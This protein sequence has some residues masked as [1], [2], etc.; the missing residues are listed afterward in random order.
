MLS[1]KAQ[2]LVSRYS[3]EL[4]LSDSGADSIVYRRLWPD[5]P[6]VDAK[7]VLVG[8]VAAANRCRAVLSRGVG[9]CTVV[10]TA[11]RPRRGR[12]ARHLAARPGAAGHARPR[13]QT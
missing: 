4:L 10:G 5:A 11:V 9:L 6:Y 8:E 13:V 7:T 3:L 1:A 2:E 12:A